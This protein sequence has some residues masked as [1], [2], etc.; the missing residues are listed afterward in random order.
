MNCLS[1]LVPELVTQSTAFTLIDAASG[2]CWVLTYVL[3]IQRSYVDKT[4]GVPLAAVCANISWEFFFSF[5][6]PH[7]PPQLYFNIVW[8]VL[9]LVILG[10]VF[11][12]WKKEF[13]NVSPD[14]FYPGALLS[15]ATSLM[16]VMLVA[17]EFNA[18]GAYSAFGDN[19][20]MSILFITMLIRRDSVRGQSL[21]IAVL[22]M[23]G[24]ALA[25]LA[26]F[27]FSTISQK[28][29]LLPFLF[30]AIL[31]SDAIYAILLV[32][33]CNDQGI[34]PWKRL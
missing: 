28:S 11:T 2:I 1:L 23:S 29:V 15:L 24:T 10:Q 4:F 26:A 32:Q 6:Q 14:L 30:V 16:L 5:F 13:P 12:Y 8:F 17:R 20:M 7:E 34:N 18:C 3:V 27:T 21:Y 31:I 25:S 33:K 9:D 19:L 22:K